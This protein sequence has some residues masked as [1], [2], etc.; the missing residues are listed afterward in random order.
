M[1]CLAVA[2]GVGALT[3][4]AASACCSCAS[5]EAITTES[6]TRR[7]RLCQR[8]ARTILTIPAIG[9]P[10][11][12]VEGTSPVTCTGS[13]D[14]P[15]PGSRRVRQR[16]DRR[17]AH[18]VRR[19]LL[20][21][22]RLRAGDHMVVLTGQGRP[23]TGA[24]RACGD[25]RRARRARAEPRSRLT[26]ATSDPAFLATKQ[27]VVVAGRSW[28]AHRGRHQRRSTL[29]ATSRRQRSRRHPARAV[30]RSSLRRSRAPSGCAPALD[31]AALLSVARSCSA[32]C[33]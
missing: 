17:P 8:L 4:R 6:S 15:T 30:G 28:Q 13:G 20:P 32:C 25:T 31:E 1:A 2:F 14:I 22:A 5:H 16:G 33:C 26:L 24:R 12:V 3:R 19:A 9:L 29:R 23:P 10:P 18:D 11:V 21:S 7:P 27:L